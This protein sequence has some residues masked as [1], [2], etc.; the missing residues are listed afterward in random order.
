MTIRR[1]PPKPV[2]DGLHTISIS[3]CSPVEM[4]AFD[5]GS[6]VSSE[7]QS[8]RRLLRTLVKYTRESAT[9]ATEN[10]QG[11][12]IYAHL[13]LAVNDKEPIRP[14]AQFQNRRML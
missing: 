6:R 11:W 1:L 10:K 9:V 4:M 3:G 7:A 13:L 5:L 12:N 2:L 14:E 8:G